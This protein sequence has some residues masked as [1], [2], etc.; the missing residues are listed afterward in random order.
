MPLMI[1]KAIFLSKEDPMPKHNPFAE[2]ADRIMLETLIIGSDAIL[3]QE[4]RGQQKLLHTDALPL[5]GTT[6]ARFPNEQ[7]N[8]S[9]LE[10]LGFTFGESIDDLFIACTLPAGWKKRGS[11]HSMWSYLDDAQGNERAGI[12][13]KAAFYDRKAHISWVRRYTIEQY[14]NADPSLPQLGDKDGIPNC[15]VVRDR[16][17]KAALFHT[18]AVTVPVYNVRHEEQRQPWLDANERLGALQE[19]AGIWL[20]E[21]YPASGDPFA[22][23]GA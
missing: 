11:S 12:F 2:S 3:M 9:A 17:T 8:Q 10:A 23:W 7:S 21:H 13:Y 22:Y 14:S 5:E 20:T 18:A 4:A 1:W 15:W 6:Q 16:Q 19:E